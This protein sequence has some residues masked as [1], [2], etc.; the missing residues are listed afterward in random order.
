MEGDNNSKPRS[1]GDT[2]LY[3]ETGDLTLLLTLLLQTGVNQ[4]QTY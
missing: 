2:M 1:L 3:M 4:E